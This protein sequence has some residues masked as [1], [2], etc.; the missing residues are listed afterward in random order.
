MNPGQDQQMKETAPVFIVVKSLDYTLR[1]R[2]E[3]LK[4]SDASHTR[5]RSSSHRGHRPIASGKKRK[6]L[7][8]LE[9]YV[10]QK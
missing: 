1:K 4:G 6:S 2:Q 8:D 5:M 3:N 10:H 9:L 7:V